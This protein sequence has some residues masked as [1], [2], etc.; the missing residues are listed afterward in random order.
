MCYQYV[1]NHMVLSVCMF[2]TI[3]IDFIYT[4]SQ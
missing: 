3:H 4:Q 2:L 1:C